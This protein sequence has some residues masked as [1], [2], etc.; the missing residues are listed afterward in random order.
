MLAM[1]LTAVERFASQSAA[2]W[3]VYLEI[4]TFPAYSGPGGSAR[5]YSVVPENGDRACTAR[6]LAEIFLAEHVEEK[7]K[8]PPQPQSWQW[9]QQLWTSWRCIQRGELSKLEQRPVLEPTRGTV[10]AAAQSGG[11]E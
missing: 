4:R 9:R 2:E 7:R 5:F 1:I 3:A 11:Y 8:C 10:V 6:Y